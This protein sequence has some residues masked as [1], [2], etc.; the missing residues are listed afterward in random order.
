MELRTEIRRRLRSSRDWATAVG[1]LELELEGV[2][3]PVE[4]SDGLY[5]IGLVA[6]EVIPDRERALGL[7]QK[8]WKQNAKNA[9]PLARMRAVYREMGRLPELV[10][11]G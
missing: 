1:E 8:A 2:S 7:Y 4:R 10:A 5:E 9:K 3:S 11:A 6:E